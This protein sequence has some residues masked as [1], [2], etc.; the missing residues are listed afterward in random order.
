MR[1]LLIQLGLLLSTITPSLAVTQKIVITVQPGA[2]QTFQGFGASIFPWTPSDLYKK[3]VSASENTAMARLLWHD[4]HFRSARIWIHPGDE[5]T[6]FYVDGYVKSG[7]VPAA[8]AAGLKDLILA[9]DRI[10]PSMNDGHGFI[11]D[12][13]MKPYAALLADFIYRF[14]E[15]SGV[16]INHCGVLNEPNDRPVKFSNAQWPLIIRDLRSAL[17]ARGL[18]SVDIVAPESANCGD[19]A[20]AAVDAIKSDPVAWA[21]LGGIATHSYNNAA[22]EEMAERRGNK[23]YWI[24]EAGGM[25]DTDEVPGDTLQ[26]ASAASRFLNDV[27]HEVTHWQYFIGAEQSDPKGN[28][29]RILKFDVNPF[30]LTVLEKYW[31]LKQLAEAFPVGARFRHCTS[32]LDGEMNYGYVTAPVRKSHLN[33]AIAQ[34]TDGR[35][36][37]GLSNFTS[38]EFASGSRP[39]WVNKQGGYPAE[40]LS[41][42]VFVRELASVPIVRF[43]VHRAST[44]LVAEV[45]MRH[46]YVYVPDIAPLDLVTLRSLKGNRRK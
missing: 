24:T 32:S 37:I 43:A 15:K 35:W 46:G 2:R 22:T 14:R 5:P 18:K 13:S 19:D 42:T 21:D 41:V 44:K 12:V 9:P 17:N 29:G 39:D 31:Y 7:K 33:A 3:E 30:K 25:T 23:S 38:N 45:V 26:A 34:D 6:D 36:A 11:K 8:I 16:L 4:A 20:Y 28:S 40:T 10:P 27:N 1:I